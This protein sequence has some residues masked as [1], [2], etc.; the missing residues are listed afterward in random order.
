MQV[1]S[2]ALEAAYFGARP[3]SPQWVIVS[4]LS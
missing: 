2:G 1:P 4:C 3:L